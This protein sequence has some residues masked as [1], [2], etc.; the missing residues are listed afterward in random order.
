MPLNV[1]NECEACRK[2][3][4]KERR[5][6]LE[7]RLNIKWAEKWESIFVNYDFS[8]NNGSCRSIL[9]CL[10]IAFLHL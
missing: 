8:K 3:L 2:L 1:R 7:E 10:E 6:S 4:E 5:E 9:P